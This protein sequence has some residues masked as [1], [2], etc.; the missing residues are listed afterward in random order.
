MVSS[1]EIDGLADAFD[2]FAD[3]GARKAFTHTAGEP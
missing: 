3:H 1:A 2:S